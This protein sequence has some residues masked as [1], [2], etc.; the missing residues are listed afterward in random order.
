M[1]RMRLPAVLLLC[2]AL[3]VTAGAEGVTL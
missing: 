3:C 2:L 1:K